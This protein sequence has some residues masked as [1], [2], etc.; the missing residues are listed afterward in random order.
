M[1]L[2]N[3]IALVTGA[4][5]GIGRAAA[6]LFACEGASVVVTDVNA[7][8]AEETAHRIAA[9]GG[10]ALGLACDVSE[11]E[12]IQAMMTRIEA[13]YGRLDVLYNNAGVSGPLGGL[14]DV[15]PADWATVMRINLDGTFWCCRAAMPL[16]LA[17]GRGAIINQSSVAALVGGGPPHLGPVTAYN[18]SKAAVIALTRSIAYEFGDRGIRCNAILPGSVRTGMTG[19]ALQSEKY[20]SAVTRSTPMGR[21]GEPEEVARTALFLASDAASFVTGETLVVDGGYVTAQG[22]VFTTVD[23]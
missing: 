9:A 21:F 20:V 4:G 11:S 1:Q 12:Q 17:G 13:E 18:A 14:L 16:M 3:K 7:T 6:E 19:P 15:D 22:P 8:T 10:T 5:S 2:A 23:L